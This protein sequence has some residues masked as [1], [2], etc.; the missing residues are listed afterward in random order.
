M[1]YLY[2]LYIIYTITEIRKDNYILRKIFEVLTRKYSLKLKLP[3]EVEQSK[4]W[5]FKEVSTSKL[6]QFFN[7]TEPSHLFTSI[8]SFDTVHPTSRLPGLTV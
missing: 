4:L 1:Y 3:I 6:M 5:Q 8:Q 2:Y 7:T